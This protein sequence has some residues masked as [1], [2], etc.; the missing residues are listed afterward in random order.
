MAARREHGG[1]R[2]GNTNPREEGGEGGREREDR[3][4]T[5][6]VGRRAAS[7]EP[8]WGR[9]GRAR[10]GGERSCMWGGGGG[11]GEG[12][13]DFGGGAAG[14]WAP[15]GRAAAPTARVGHGT[16]AGGGRLGREGG[17]EQAATGPPSRPKAGEGGRAGPRGRD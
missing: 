11:L 5:W 17:S 1:G 2:R 9:G 7:G 14:G 6:A 12:E 13:G 16:R 15:L 3:G 4:S 8:G 10:W